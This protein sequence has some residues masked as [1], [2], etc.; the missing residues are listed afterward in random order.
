MRAD[1]SRPFF[2]MANLMDVHGV[3]LVPEPY[4]SRFGAIPMPGLGARV[5]GRLRQVLGG[6]PLPVPDGREPE[7]YE[8][9]IARL[10][11]Q[12][13][14]F[15]Q[16]L[17]RG[18]VLDNTIVILTSDHGEEFREHGMY[19]HGISLYWPAIHVPLIVWLPGGRSAGLRVAGPV[20]LR[21]LPATIADLAGLGTAPFPG[22][23]LA[24]AWSGGGLAPDTVLA[25]LPHPQPTAVRGRK[26]LPKGPMASVVLD[27]L[28][29]IRYA[30]GSEEVFDIAADPWERSNLLDRI[31]PATLDRARALL[32]AAPTRSER[33]P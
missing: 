10:D 24:G 26:P 28:H 20:S 4:A 11:D 13:G 21:T 14:A 15:F 8:A 12:L 23:S 22:R 3:Y 18:G 16:D 29:L 1:A 19:G 27:S 33:R 32:P 17:E 2:A 6:E 30:D 25:E 5:R 9:A 31:A 7:G